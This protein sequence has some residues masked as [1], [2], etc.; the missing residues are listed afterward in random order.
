MSSDNSI[1]GVT[2]SL[3]SPA[4]VRNKLPI[5]PTS[6]VFIKN[7]REEIL[8][9]LQGKDSRTLLIVGPCSIHDPLAAKEFAKHLRQ[10]QDEVKHS[11][12]LVMRTYFAKPRTQVGWKGLLYDP[13]LDETFSLVKGI[14]TT[15][16]LLL[17]L[18][19]L[20]IPIATEFLDPLTAFYFDDLIS[21]G[22][23]GA[24][25]AE[26]Q[27]HRELASTLPM[28][29]AFKNNT[30]GDIGIA[31]NG[32]YTASFPHTFF[33]INDHGILSKRES[34]GNPYPHIVLRGGKDH[35][36]YDPKSINQAIQAVNKSK[37]S[38]RLLIDCSHDNAKNCHQ[39][40]VLVFES[41]IRQIIEGN[42]DISGMI[43]ES[44]LL[45]GKQENLGQSID[46]LQYGCS[47]TDPCIDWE[48][49]KKLILWGHER[50]QKEHTLK[51]EK[52]TVSKNVSNFF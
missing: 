41:I 1:N 33:S 2:N 32:A 51:N 50:M 45:S 19:E 20:E 14:E 7:K 40:Q 4:E 28:P 47:I 9:I 17:H 6:Q 37:I 48:T 36:N 16:S 8:S 39:E 26:S 12:L 15:R 10:L 44:H 27:I 3:P 35:T 31:I 52:T 13:G 23:I 18:T 29:I 46:S 42:Q 49:T 30:L 5:S 22:C 24:R 43:L 11:F 38:S 34:K 25:T 21:W